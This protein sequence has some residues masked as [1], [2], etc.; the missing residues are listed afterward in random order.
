MDYKEWLN[1]FGRD[2]EDKKVKDALA[3]VGVKKIPPIKKDDTDTRVML[4][5]SML[6]FSSPE[7]FPSHEA[8]GD[9]SSILNALVLPLKGKKWGEYKRELPFQLDRADSQKK[10]RARLGEPIEHNEDFYWDQWKVDN[11][12]L[13]VT[14][15]ED[16][17]S[18]TVV[19]VELPTEV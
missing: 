19:A 9:G 2:S 16:L 8:G 5:D 15:T 11:L 3:K 4:G 7:L 12:L 17:G 14:Y 13:R 1:L 10:L 18:L 6:I